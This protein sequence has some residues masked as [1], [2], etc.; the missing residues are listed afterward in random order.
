MSCSGDGNSAGLRLTACAAN[1]FR[2]LFGLVELERHVVGR[3][4]P[5]GAKLTH[6]ISQQLA[7]TA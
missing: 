1:N 5:H 7:C 2:N 6:Q 3:R 4:A